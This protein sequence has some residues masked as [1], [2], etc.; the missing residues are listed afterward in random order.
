MR[1]HLGLLLV[2]AAVASAG[3]ARGPQV[4]AEAGGERVYESE[5]LQEEA[6]ARAQGTLADAPDSPGLMR[7]YDRTV[8]ELVDRKL[9]RQEA[10]RRGLRVP[11]EYVE[12]EVQR[13]RAQ[14]GGE[15]G[16]RQ[17]LERYRMGEADLRARIRE[18]K[19]VELLRLEVAR[20]VR[21]T[22]EDALRFYRDHLSEFSTPARSRMRL[23]LFARRE[24]AEAARRA[25]EQGRRTFRDFAS[26][27]LGQDPEGYYE[28][29]RGEDPHLEPLA[30]SS[31]VGRLQGPARVGALWAVYR[32]E[33]VFPPE[34]KPFSQVREVVLQ[35]ARSELARRALEDLLQRLRRERGVR[36]HRTYW[37]GV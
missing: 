24:D 12:A 11:D 15:Q 1:V 29:R 37:Q 27:R 14:A 18:L 6:V 17:L 20:S 23:L 7:F 5:V 28:V 25:L 10:E 9:L 16:F 30:F 26:Y 8:R 32:V 19:L 2:V 3:C 34:P 22:H 13:V 21:V 31:P 33:R 36:I 4:V 35:R